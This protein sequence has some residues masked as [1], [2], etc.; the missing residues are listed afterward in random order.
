MKLKWLIVFALIVATAPVLAADKGKNKSKSNDK[1]RLELD[2]TAIQGASELPKVLYIVPWKK[3]AP[4]NKPVRLKSMVD[5]VMAPVDREV[6]ERQLQFYHNRTA[7][8]DDEKVVAS[9][10]AKATVKKPAVE[11]K[12]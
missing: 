5:E 1:D 6:L 11:K 3:N 2:E 4:D 7:A 9:K 10:P 12:K 8:K